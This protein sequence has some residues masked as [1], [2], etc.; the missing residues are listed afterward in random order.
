LARRT[1]MTLRSAGVKSAAL[2]TSL[3]LSVIWIESWLLYE[4]IQNEQNLGNL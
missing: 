2:S 3:L 4:K 1:R